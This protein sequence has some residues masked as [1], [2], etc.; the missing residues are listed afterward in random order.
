[1]RSAIW[2]AKAM[3]TMVKPVRPQDCGRRRS[4]GGM[5]RHGRPVQR[6]LQRM[7][8]EGGFDVVARQLGCCGV[9][10][11]DHNLLSLL[12]VINLIKRPAAGL[13]LGSIAPGNK[14]APAPSAGR[15]A[16]SPAAAGIEPLQLLP[17]RRC[18]VLIGRLILAA[19]FGPDL[20]C[21]FFGVHTK[22]ARAGSNSGQ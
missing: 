18:R 1:M 11:R 13:R 12:G 20:G 6:P 21:H 2:R 8:A 19:L 15:D 3:A 7:V 4:T 9:R 16:V 10:W 5:A 14:S 22:V 17:A